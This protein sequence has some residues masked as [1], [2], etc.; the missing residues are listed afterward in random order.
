MSLRSVSKIDLMA[1]F[2]LYS[3]NVDTPPIPAILTLF[4]SKFILNAGT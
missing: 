1:P 2:L 3:G 4:P